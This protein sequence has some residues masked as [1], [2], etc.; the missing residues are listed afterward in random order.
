[1]TAIDSQRKNE[2]SQISLPLC[3]D[4]TPYDLERLYPDQLLMVYFILER[5]HDWFTCEDLSNFIPGLFLLMGQGGTGKSVIL[6][7]S[8]AVVRRKFCYTDTVGATGPTGSSAFNVFGMTLHRFTG[9][10]I[11]GEYKPN[12]MSAA[13]RHELVSRFK[14]LLCL[15][16]DERS[17]LT[18]KLLGSTA[19]IIAETIFGGSKKFELFGGLPVLVLA[20]DD[21]QLPGMLEGALEALTRTRGSPMTQKGR[22]IFRD[23]AKNVLKLKTIRRVCDSEPTANKEMVERVRIGD[24]IQDRDVD[25]ILSLHLDVMKAK[26]G[27]RVVEQIEKDAVFLFWTNEK[28]M[29]HNHLRLLQLTS[30][31]NP[32]AIIKPFGHGEGTKQSVRRH[33]DDDPPDASLMFIGAKVCVQGKNFWPQWGLFNGACGTVEEIVF[34]K[35]K[36]PN[37]GDHPKYV[38]VN[39][40]QYLGPIWDLDNPKVNK[41]DYCAITTTCSNFLL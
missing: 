25:K 11:K 22:S 18:S 26:H 40:P 30:D 33:F 8:T 36:N 21:Y 16:I 32:V 37:K 7:T 34:E 12:T 23:C 10:G 3:P 39:F 28:R 14:H 13:K 1:V 4:G 17:L 9:Q 38:V 27:P 41:V 2:A 31:E 19:Q 15:I 5:L 20:G 24:Q 6:N 35:G 29:R